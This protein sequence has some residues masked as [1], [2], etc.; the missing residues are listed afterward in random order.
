MNAERYPEKCGNCGGPLKSV[1]EMGNATCLK[2]FDAAVAAR[3]E[4]DAVAHP[5]DAATA[6]R[7]LQLATANAISTHLRTKGEALIG[8]QLRAGV[9]M[10]CLRQMQAGTY[11]GSLTRLAK[12]AAAMGKVMRVSFD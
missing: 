10:H 5:P 12:V 7:A 2:C 9:C 1:W 8:L 6:L 4:A 11:H 3:R